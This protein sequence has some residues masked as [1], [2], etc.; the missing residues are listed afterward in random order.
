MGSTF[1]WMPAKP[2]PVPFLSP[3]PSILTLGSSL[4]SCV[5]CV[6]ALLVIAADCR[7][8]QSR[9]SPHARE[10][11]QLTSPIPPEA[12]PFPDSKR[13]RTSVTIGSDMGAGRLWAAAA[14]RIFRFLAR[15]KSETRA[16]SLRRGAASNPRGVEQRL[17]TLRSRSAR[18]LC[19]C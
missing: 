17:T 10:S 12:A 7:A 4:T 5:L 15:K 8:A 14:T 19:G 9:T 6:A 16:L 11:K 2:P 1:A 3:P 13:S 18:G